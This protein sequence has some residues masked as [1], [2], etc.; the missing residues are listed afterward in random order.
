MSLK[1][2]VTALRSLKAELEATRRS[3]L[4]LE[5][6]HRGLVQVCVFAVFRKQLASFWSSSLFAIDCRAS[7][8][9]P[10]H[11]IRSRINAASVV[12]V[13]RAQETSRAT[14]VPLFISSSVSNHATNGACCAKTRAPTDF[15]YKYSY[16]S[17]TCFVVRS[18]VTSIRKECTTEELVK[19]VC[20]RPATRS[21]SKVYE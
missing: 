18:N 5:V 8:R 6:A 10:L 11:Y 14:A 12:E 17:S 21:P 20:P 15:I 2:A 9:A 13:Q 3:K 4:E 19:T 16:P 7:R 1:D